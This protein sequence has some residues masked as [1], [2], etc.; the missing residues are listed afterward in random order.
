MIKMEVT[1]QEVLR[2]LCEINHSSSGVRIKG[3][4]KDMSCLTL[5]DGST[6]N[7]TWD[8]VLSKETELI[9]EYDAQEYARNR[10]TEYPAIAEQLDEI[11]HNGIDSWKAVI[12]VTKD[13][14][15]K[16]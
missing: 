4:P 6:P 9:A 16:G 10:A 2:H 8:D 12:K 5:M 14:Y 13:K 11:Y 3:I 7:F 15:P 1:K